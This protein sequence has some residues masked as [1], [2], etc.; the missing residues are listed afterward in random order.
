MSPQLRPLLSHI[1]ALGAVAIIALLIMQTGSAPSPLPSD[2]VTA[3]TTAQTASVASSIPVATTT[4]TEVAPIR[5][6]KDEG[7]GQENTTA[8]EQTTEEAT[9]I[10]DPYPFS[11]EPF[12]LINEKTRA[13][14]VN[15]FCMPK[16]GTLRPISGSGVM[17]DPRGVILTNAHVA[18]YVLLSQSP[19]IDLSCTVRTGSPATAKWIPTILYLPPVWVDE[20]AHEIN[21]QH[22]MGTGAHDYALLLI[23]GATSGSPLPL[24]P[25][26]GFPYLPY[27]TREAIGFKDDTVLVAS[28]P[29]EF[30]GGIATQLNLFSASSVTTIKQLL[31]FEVGTVDL[32]SLGGIIEAQ[33]GS[34]GGAVVNAWGRLIG[35]IATTSDG[36][37]TMERDLRAITVSY[38]SRDLSVQTLFDLPTILGGD[39]RAQADDFNTTI[40]PRI[41]ETFIEELTR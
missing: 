17:I 39:V 9:R 3:T 18:Q 35:L 27:D 23:T 24:P 14:L 30:V 31:T 11:P 2:E 41:I 1:G 20:H 7:V 6:Q 12:P 33:S 34:S 40:A 25:V 32:F 28:Y 38:I 13:A 15:I 8:Q 22:P 36:A 5:P 37:T 4:P 21:D 19:Q 16:S 26:G 29:A 10:K